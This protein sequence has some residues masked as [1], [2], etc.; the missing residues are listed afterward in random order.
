MPKT[1]SPTQTEALATIRGAVRADSAAWLTM[2]NALW[3][4]GA[5]ESHKNEIRAY[6]DGTLHM[7]L[8]VLLA[9]D[10]SGAPVGFAELSIRTYAEG[11]TTDR[12]AYLEGWYVAPEARRKHIGA[13]LIRAA[14]EWGVAQ[15]C[16]EFG[17]DAKLDNDVS[18]QAHRALGF[19]ETV[20]IRCFRKTLPRPRA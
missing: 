5:G 12:V 10:G 18:A 20:E 9:V 8:Q 3:P 1:Q 7:P 15:G 13:A 11:C 4:E 17:S 6:F 2:R 16:T 19:E 14:E